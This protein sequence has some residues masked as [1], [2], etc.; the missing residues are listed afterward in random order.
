MNNFFEQIEIRRLLAM[1]MCENPDSNVV[2]ELMAKYGSPRDLVNVTEEELRQIRGIGV[3]KARQLRSIIELSRRLVAATKDNVT[4]IRNP[5]DAAHLV[6]EEMRFLDREY[7]RCILLT[8]KNQVI[9]VET[10]SVGSLNSSI[11]HPRE[12]FKTPLK[13]SAAA[14]VLVHNHPS[15]DPTPS[16]EDLDV[17]KRLVECGKLLGIEVLDHVVVGDQ[18]YVSFKEQGLI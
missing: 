9:R 3:V 5:A 17:T 4:V 15:G 16:K 12:V 14:V 10:V 13:C 7:F 8:T 6:M 11:V 2:A 1:S 18:R